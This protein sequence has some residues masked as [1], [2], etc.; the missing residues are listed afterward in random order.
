MA[1]G[2]SAFSDKRIPAYGSPF[3]LSE[4]SNPVSILFKKFYPFP[5][6]HWSEVKTA[7]RSSTLSSKADPQKRN[8][9][10][11]RKLLVVLK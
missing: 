5:A 7:T 9:L 1:P 11:F 6:R 10:F 4:N 2:I 3:L 8:P